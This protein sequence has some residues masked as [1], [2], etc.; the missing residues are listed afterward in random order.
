M[1]IIELSDDM[2]INEVRKA[3][4]NGKEFVFMLST[5]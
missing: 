4:I 3:D 5:T 2:T 1:K